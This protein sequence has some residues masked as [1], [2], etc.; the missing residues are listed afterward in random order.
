[1]SAPSPAPEAAPRSPKPG[2]LEVSTRLTVAA[3]LLGLLLAAV[4]RTPL[5]GSPHPPDTRRFALELL[6]AYGFPLVL[7]GLILAV[8]MVA[9]VA[10]AKEDE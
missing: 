1:M 10:L 6:S 5:P 7:I 8:A 4:L 2:I 3:L 9:G